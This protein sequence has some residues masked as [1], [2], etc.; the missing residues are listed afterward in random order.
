MLATP[1][2]QAGAPLL[3]AKVFGVFKPRRGNWGNRACGILSVADKSL[4]RDI[5]ALSPEGIAQLV[6]R[7][8]RNDAGA[9]TLTF[10]Y[11]LFTAPP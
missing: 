10:S 4:R 5:F 3:A 8:V 6:E 11:A 9:N 2:A 1:T 7:L